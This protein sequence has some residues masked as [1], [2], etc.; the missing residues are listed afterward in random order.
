MYT[1]VKC[2]LPIKPLFQMRVDLRNLDRTIVNNQGLEISRKHKSKCIDNC[3]RRQDWNLVFIIFFRTSSKN[4]K[5]KWWKVTVLWNPYKFMSDKLSIGKDVQDLKMHMKKTG[6]GG[7]CGQWLEVTDASLG[8]PPSCTM[9]RRCSWGPQ[10]PCRAR[11]PPCPAGSRPAGQGGRHF[12][13]KEGE[14]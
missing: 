9:C 4:K 6:L 12:N 14:D 13:F 7:I 3:S 5:K 10:C 2:F 1:R 11:W 8:A